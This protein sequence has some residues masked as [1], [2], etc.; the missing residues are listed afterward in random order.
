MDVVPPLLRHR[1][2]FWVSVLAPLDL[3]SPSS[4]RLAPHHASPLSASAVPLIAAISPSCHTGAVSLTPLQLDLSF[5]F[6]FMFMLVM[7]FFW[8]SFVRF[9]T[10]IY[11]FVSLTDPSRLISMLSFHWHPSGCIVR[12]LLVRYLQVLTSF[13]LETAFSGPAREARIIFDPLPTI[14]VYFL[15]CNFRFGRIVGEPTPYLVF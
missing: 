12:C 5:G 13:D 1:D 9:F 2:L 11:Q 10:T 6:G 3:E 15:H 8:N 7:L 14:C 4:V